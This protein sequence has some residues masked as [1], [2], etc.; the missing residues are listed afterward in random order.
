MRALIQR[1]DGARCEVDGRVTGR[2]GVGL[3]VLLGIHVGDTDADAAWIAQRL[4]P[5]RVFPDDQGRMNLSLLQVLA[6]LGPASG[7]GVLLVPNFTLCASTGKGHRPGFDR[8]MPP[9]RARAMYDQ[10]A[11]RVADAGVPVSTGVFGA[12]MRVT[13]TNDGPVTLLLDSA[14]H[15]PG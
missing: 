8:A 10:V 5:L 15:R 1:V 9:D 12:H 14:D 4:P 11:A 3:A 2:I 7:V 13:L 6:A